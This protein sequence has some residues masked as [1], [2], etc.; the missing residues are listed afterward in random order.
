MKKPILNSSQGGGEFDYS[1]PTLEILSVT[2]EQGF[3]AS[4]PSWEDYGDY[5]FAGDDLMDDDY[6]DYGDF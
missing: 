2:V 5:G 1:A 4:D 3:A 6:Y